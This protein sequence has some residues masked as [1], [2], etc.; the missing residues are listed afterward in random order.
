MA[1]IN[2]TPDHDTLNGGDDADTLNGG[3]GNDSLN[4]GGGNDT[5]NGEV[6]D[7]TLDGG[8]G[9]DSMTG[10]LGN[11]I[12][13][14]DGAGDLVVEALNEGIDEVRTAL[15]GYSLLGTNLENLRALS[16]IAHD[17]RGNSS[18][19]VITG[20]AGDDFLR[21][22]D[23]G[24]DTVIAGAGNDAI[25]FG[26]S[27]T[28]GDVVDGGA[29]TRD[30]LGLQGDYG[31]SEP[32]TLSASAL[33]NVEMLVLLSGAD[34]RFGDTSGNLY[35]YRINTRDVNVPAGQTL[36]VSFNT[37]RFGEDVFFDGS[38]E[39]DGSFLFYGG[40]GYERLRGGQQ[41][42]AFYFGADGRFGDTPTGP[43]STDRVEGEG[44]NDQLGLQGDYSGPR[45]L[46]FGDSSMDSIEMIVLLSAGDNRFG[47]GSADGY[48]YDLLMHNFN[49][50]NGARLIIS[51][52]T[53]RSDGTL[54]ETLVFNGINETDGSFTIYAGDGA[55]VIVG[56]ARSDEIWGR[57]GD[58]LITG[59]LGGDVLRGGD[60]NDMFDYNALAESTA[61]F[62]DR[63]LILD[64]TSG[65]DK[66]NL[67]DIDANTL[68][69]G[70]HG[71]TWIGSSAF[72]GNGTAGSGVA[73][74]LRAFYDG[75]AWIVEGDVNADGI[76]DFQI[77][78]VLAT[79]DPLVASDF[80][81]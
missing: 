2:G 73:G 71:F 47:G 14:V 5:L 49:V 22:Q 31:R 80:L 30:Q 61:A 21:L 18:N 9:D 55:D 39:T 46:T 13:H 69:A 51:A 42:D 26:R 1:V 79:S 75:S 20:G 4:G 34:A 19:N 28:S 74:E 10:G 23:G 63:D 11:D 33:V 52:N 66:I 67:A 27:L 81:L 57:G 3:D 62:R 35:S 25:Y 37:L 36:T 41:N 16:D 58:D 50:L 60:G 17:F 6:G 32:I 64:F 29:G 7:D 59:R 15:A 56:G 53:L 48:S 40:L 68:V 54:N 70:E 72:S 44:G 45:A 8:A 12:Y 77:A 24:D 38:A 78:V 65:S 76:G 43:G